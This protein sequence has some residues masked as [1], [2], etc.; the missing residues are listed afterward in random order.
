M[1]Q[2]LMLSLGLGADRR[3]VTTIEYAVLAGSLVL[4]VSGV[5]SGM[6][7]VLHAKL[8]NMVNSIS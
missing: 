6:G 2:V 8:L 7:S 4:L 3:A 1:V 5:L